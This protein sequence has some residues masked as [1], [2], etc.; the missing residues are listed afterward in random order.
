MINKI[1]QYFYDSWIQTTGEGW[2]KKQVAV[3]YAFSVIFALAVVLYSV[4]ADL[5]WSWIQMAV[6]G[7]IAW[8]LGGGV[9]GYNHKAIKQRQLKEKNNVHYYHHNLQHIHPL[10]LVF[11]NNKL[12][13]PI[14]AIYWFATFMIYVEI[15]EISPRTGERKISKTGE[16][17]VV[18][19]EVLIAVFLIILSFIVPDVDSRIKLF[20]ILIYGALPILTFI[21]LKVP[22]AFQRTASIMMVSTMLIAGMYIGAPKG[23]EWLIPIYYL[24]LLTGFTAKE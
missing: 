3:S 2:T 17:V 19:Y 23:F 24:K 7:L 14:L 10:I 16:V 22:V 1:D 18:G 12:I 11:F 15:L 4:F 9:L 5:K 13:L 6:V 20:G 8:D 21:L